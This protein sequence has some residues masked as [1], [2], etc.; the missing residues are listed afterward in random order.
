[1]FITVDVKQLR[2]QTNLHFIFVLIRAWIERSNSYTK[3]HQISNSC[4]H[5]VL[6]LRLLMSYIY[7][8]LVA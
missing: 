2:K 5:E 7:T 3:W 1:V 4:A 8:K 6:T